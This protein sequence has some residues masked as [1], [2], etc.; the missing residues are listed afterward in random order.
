MPSL[1][2]IWHAFLPIGQRCPIDWAAPPTRTG[3]PSFVADDVLDRKS[4]RLNSSHDQISYAV[5][6]L[7][8]KKQHSRGS[9]LTPTN[10]LE[11]FRL[12][13]RLGATGLE[14]YP[15]LTTAALPCLAYTGRVRYV[16]RH[17]C[18]A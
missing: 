3:G 7:K 17:T 10:T 14:R 12:G 1:C 6:C 9:A 11:A 15:W 5:F 13:L 8:K 2:R 4:T 18:I 16:T